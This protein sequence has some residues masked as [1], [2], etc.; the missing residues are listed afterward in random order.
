MLTSASESVEYSEGAG[1]ELGKGLVG[2]GVIELEKGLLEG[3]GVA[4]GCF[5][6]MVALTGDAVID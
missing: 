2:E 3:T 6:M 5:S 4:G 1:E